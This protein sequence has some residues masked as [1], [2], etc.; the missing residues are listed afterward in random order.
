MNNRWGCYPEFWQFSLGKKCVG[1]NSPLVSQIILKIGRVILPSHCASVRVLA[2]PWC[3]TR[4]LNRYQTWRILSLL[5]FTEIRG[6]RGHAL[7]SRSAHILSYIIIYV[8]ILLYIMSYYHILFYIVLYYLILSNV[9]SYY[10]IL[11]YII[12]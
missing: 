6:Y 10:D 9:V 11:S 4:W 12:L 5:Y 3:L 7:Q 8:H 2:S 1:Y